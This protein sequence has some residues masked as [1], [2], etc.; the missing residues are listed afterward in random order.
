MIYNIV[1]LITT[2][3]FFLQAFADK[4]ISNKAYVKPLM[5]NFKTQ[6]ESKIRSRIA[7]PQFQLEG[8][9]KLHLKAMQVSL[10]NIGYELECHWTG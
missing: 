5:R 10:K 8:S 9:R 1:P 6:S 4:Q 3:V 7:K 2:A